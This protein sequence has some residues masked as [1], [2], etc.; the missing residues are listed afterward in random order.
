M[1]S[2]ESARNILLNNFSTTPHI[3]IKFNQTVPNEKYYRL[4]CTLTGS[5]NEIFYLYLGM[6]NASSQWVYDNVFPI[7]SVKTSNLSNTS[8][9]Q[10]FTTHN[11]VVSLQCQTKLQSSSSSAFSSYTESSATRII[12]ISLSRDSTFFQ[13]DWTAP[14]WKDIEYNA[15]IGSI[16]GSDQV[17]L[18]D[19]SNIQFTFPQATA[20]YGTSIA[21]YRITIP[22]AF[23]RSYTPSVMAASNYKIYLNLAAYPKIASS[24]TIT[25]EVEDSRGLVKKYTSALTI[26]P[27]I[28]P[29]VNENNTHRQS[30]TGSTVILDFSG[31][32]LGGALTLTCNGITAY[33]EGSSTPTYTLSASVSVVDNTFSY[34][35]TWTGFDPSKAYSIYIELGDGIKTVICLLRIPVGTPTVSVRNAKVGINVPEPQSTL[36]VG[37]IIVQNDYPVMGYV[38]KIGDSSSANLNNYKDTGFYTYESDSSARV[39]NFPDNNANQHLLLEVI[40]AVGWSSYDFGVQKAW[41]PSTGDEYRRTFYG[42][43]FQSWKKVTMT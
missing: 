4:K 14:T 31:Q 28:Y 18:Q 17:G 37:G 26:K 16:T 7:E 30:G 40:N 41:N 19:V 12:N 20:K 5:S 13:P 3:G 23:T 1:I 27:Y 42:N 8:F 43:L 29:T 39:Y 11:D 32:W 6:F 22:D 36:D 9:Q 10:I 33:E 24:R 35:G 15:T 25:F 21:E 38:G 34:Q 2:Y